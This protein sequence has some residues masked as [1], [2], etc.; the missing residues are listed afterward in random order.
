ME[1]KVETFIKLVIPT[2]ILGDNNLTPLERLLLIHILSLCN[3]KGYCWATNEY[4]KKQYNVSKQTISKSI[5]RLSKLN[6]IDLQ[7]DLK[8]KNNSKRLIRI[9]DVFKKRISDIKENVNTGNQKNFNQYNRNNN[10]EKNIG[11]IISKD[12]DGV[13]LW[14]GVRCE[15]QP[16]SLEEKKYVDGLLSCFKKGDE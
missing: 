12:F 13:V 4:F 3:K 9:S 14:N 15:S 7:Y 1:R 2:S 10:K 5:N 6:Y 16:L 8:E 11:P